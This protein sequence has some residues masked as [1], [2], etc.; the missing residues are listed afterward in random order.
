MVKSATATK[1]VRRPYLYQHYLPLSVI[2]KI[3]CFWK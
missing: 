1:T 3:N 2:G